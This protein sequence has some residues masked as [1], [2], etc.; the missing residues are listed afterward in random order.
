MRIAIVTYALQVGGVESFIRLLA[1]YFISAGNEVD[2]IEVLKKGA[3]ADQF[4]EEGFTVRE[5]FQ[6]NFSSAVSHAE[7]IGKDLQ[8]YDAVLLNDVPAA[9]SA[10]GLL[11]DDTAA[12]PVVHQSFLQ[13]MIDTAVQN[14]QNWDSV[15]GV[16]P[17]IR[18]RIR[19]KN[20][21]PGDIFYIP[22]GVEVPVSYPRVEDKGKKLS[23][24]FAGAITHVQKGVLYLPEIIGK[25]LAGRSSVTFSIVGDGAD[26]PVLKE[27]C[28]AFSLDSVRFYGNIPHAEV[29]RMMEKTDILLFPSHFEGMPLVLLEA[30][31]NGVVPAASYLPGCTDAVITHDVDGFLLPVGDIAG[32]GEAITALTENRERL[33]RLSLAA[34]TK[35]RNEFSYQETGRKYLALIESCRKKRLE[36]HSERTGELDY[37]LL[38]GYPSLPRFAVRP[39]RRLRRLLHFER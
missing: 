20:I 30:M 2:I 27:R 34:W 38:G 1:K 23:V 28:S 17:A 10:L 22:N 25:V 11:R 7:V 21:K 26:L 39:V 32:F 15:V 13:N 33:H 6:G 31:S 14:A 19:Q 29:L 35:V 12:I 5:I 37:S 8:T 24:L 16:G 18:E 4:R 36:F 9:Q 3:T